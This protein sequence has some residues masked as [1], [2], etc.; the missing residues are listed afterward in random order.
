MTF[1]PFKQPRIK[2]RIKFLLSFVVLSLLPLILI[3][4]SIIFYLSTVQKQNA[5]QLGQKIAQSASQEISAFMVSQFG[6]LK[7]VSSIYLDNSIPT[8]LQ[9]KLVERI[10]YQNSDFQDL[11]VVDQTGKEISRKNKIKVINQV[12]LKDRSSSPEFKLV[13]EQGYYLGSLEIIEG[14]PLILLGQPIKDLG[15]DFRGVVFAWVDARILQDVVVNALPVKSDNEVYIVDS[16]GRVIAHPDISQVL[17]ESDFSSVPVIKPIANGG[18][19][20]IFPLIYQ[21]HSNNEVLGMAIPVKI[22]SPIHQS[23]LTS[24][25]FV[26]VEQPTS[27]TFAVVRSMTIYMIVLTLWV[28][29]FALIT[30]TF[31]AR[32]IVKPIEKLHSASKDLGQGVLNSRVLIKTNDEIED[33]ASAF[34]TMADQLSI[35]FTNL[36]RDKEV[37]S[38]EKDKLSVVLSEMTDGVIAIDMETQIVI[39]NTAAENITGYKSQ[40]VLGRKISDVIKVWDKEQELNTLAYCP[41][42]SSTEVTSQ[43]HNDI[44]IQ[45]RKISYVKLV[46]GQIKEGRENNLGCILTMHDVTSEKQLEQMKLEF[47]AM[48]AHELRTPLTSLKGYIYFLKSKIYN[49]IDA[50]GQSFLNRTEVS[51]QKLSSLI[52]NLLNITGIEGNRV[53][54]NMENLDWVDNVASV[55]AEIL[56]EAKEKK[57]DISIL[58]PSEKFPQIK[59][60]K[61]RINEVLYN[62]IANAITFTNGGGKIR[63]WFSKNEKELITNIE[64]TGV[65]MPAEVLPRLFTKFFK[66]TA[67]LTQGSKG[68]GLGL[69]I[70]KSIVDMHGGRIWVNSELGRGTTFS[71]SL[72]FK[73][74]LESTSRMLTPENYKKAISEKKYLSDVNL[75]M[76]AQKSLLSTSVLPPPQPSVPEVKG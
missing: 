72:P 57:V 51:A 6:V 3:M 69:Y 18:T 42:N 56:P 10:L 64:D 75:T 29:V 70:T 31:T 26:I 65:G 53:S 40:E 24:N 45:G 67:T 1:L 52:E 50:E 7:N 37:I 33:L 43:V 38:A 35:Y 59:A 49:Q 47:V 44:K 66:V 30:A 21:N 12:D 46:S 17:S 34:N 25:W 63:I 2:L 23:G 68:T 36:R 4:S 41:I 73:N 13:Q 54:M 74:E 9:E 11:T 16:K 15:G 58:Y 32:H 19:N 62:L 55:V 20:G 39:F 76:E 60:D 22:A 28:L 8:E 5:T 27:V 61:Y 71:F 48:A 14:K